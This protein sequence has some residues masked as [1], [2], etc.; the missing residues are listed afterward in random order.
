MAL[1]N[2]NR[3]K[4]KDCCKCKKCSKHEEKELSITA[5]IPHQ[6]Q[7]PI[8]LGEISQEEPELEENF[9]EFLKN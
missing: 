5:T 7:E 8:V 6:E 9:E 3:Q 4:L 2:L 1:D